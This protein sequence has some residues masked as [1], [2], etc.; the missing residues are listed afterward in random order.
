MVIWLYGP[1]TSLLRDFG[2]NI[3]LQTRNPGLLL[4]LSS[5]NAGFLGQA[6]KD[7]GQAGTTELEVTGDFVEQQ[8]ACIMDINHDGIVDLLDLAEFGEQHGLSCAEVA[9]QRED[10]KSTL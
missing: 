10:R 7:E 6:Q 9:E 5:C 8:A 4:S 3:H 1:I 2:P